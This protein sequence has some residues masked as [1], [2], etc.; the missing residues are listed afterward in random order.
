MAV[1]ILPMSHWQ[2]YSCP[3]SLQRP[4]FLHGKSAHVTPGKCLLH[5][6]DLYIWLY[7]FIS[8]KLRFFFMY[9]K[10]LHSSMYTQS[11]HLFFSIPQSLTPFSLKPKLCLNQSEKNFWWTQC[12]IWTV[13]F[14]NTM[15]YSRIKKA[16]LAGIY[17]IGR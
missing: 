8:H 7:L 10:F 1:E 6:Y 14:K 15:F 4:L 3:V 16:M 11:K 12:L 2:M 13:W 5:H 9:G 17:K